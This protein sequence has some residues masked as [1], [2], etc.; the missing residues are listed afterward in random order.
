MSSAVAY[1]YIFDES[2]FIQRDTFHAAFPSSFHLPMQ[3]N[4][5]LI[6]KAIN[7]G[8]IERSLVDQTA[9]VVEIF[10]PANATKNAIPRYVVDDGW[11]RRRH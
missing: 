3:L 4:Q 8:F 5:G 1:R 11:L 7:A 2:R 9:Q 6:V 10:E